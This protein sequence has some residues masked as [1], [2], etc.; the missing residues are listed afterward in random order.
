MASGQE[1]A[2]VGVV[3]PSMQ[4]ALPATFRTAWLPLL[5]LAAACGPGA[6]GEGYVLLDPQARNQGFVVEVDG[7]ARSTPLPIAVALTEGVSVVLA[8]PERRE[9]IDLEPGELAYIRGDNGARS[10]G[11]PDLDQLRVRGAES[12]VRELGSRIGVTPAEDGPARWLLKGEDVLP[13]AALLNDADAAAIFSSAPIMSETRV[14]EP[15]D[16]ADARAAVRS[17]GERASGSAFDWSDP[18]A[19]REALADFMAARSNGT[20]GRSAEE[21]AADRQAIER[22]LEIKLTALKSE[23]RAGEAIPLKAELVN[24]GLTERW[25]VAPRDGSSMGW[26]EPYVFYKVEHEVEP[27]VWEPAPTESFSRCGNY[28]VRWDEDLTALPPGGAMPLE[29]EILPLEYGFDMHKS[30]RYRIT[31]HYNYRGGAGG[32]GLY[33]F[34][35]HVP[36]PAELQGMPSFEVASAPVEVT[37]VRPIDLEVTFKAPLVITPSTPVDSVLDVTLTNGLRID[38]PLPAAGEEHGISLE[39]EAGD[40]RWSWHS[41]WD[42]PSLPFAQGQDLKSGASISV[43]KGVTIPVGHEGRGTIAPNGTTARVRASLWT[44]RYNDPRRVTVRSD[45][46]EAPIAWRGQ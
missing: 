1:L 14:E 29:R 36:I 17:A 28:A 30:G 9:A 41:M 37:V 10:F 38:L 45:W 20:A 43:L 22:D 25:L 15:L 19:E 6:A 33:A 11:T 39:I 24:R 16:F 2:R 35:E 26:R 4:R 23:V 32:R 7:E 13:I 8:G 34:G 18:Q 40:W 42:R 46:V 5:L 27:G 21:L 12:S 31:A 44:F 3:H